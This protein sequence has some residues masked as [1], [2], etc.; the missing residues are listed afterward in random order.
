MQLEIKNGI[1]FIDETTRSVRKV[2]TVVLDVSR[3]G[4]QRDLFR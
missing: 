3:E 2:N 1:V 4:V